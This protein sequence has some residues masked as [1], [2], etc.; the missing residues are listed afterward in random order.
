MQI[1]ACVKHVPDTAANI[2]VTADAA[3]DES[4]KFVVNP[5]D[6]YGV[7]E[8]IQTVNQTGEGEVIIVTVGKAAAENTMRSALAIGAHRGI[9]VKTEAQ[10]LDST[11]TALALKAAIEQ[12]G[13]PDLIFMGKQSVDSEGMQTPYRLARTFGMPVATDVVNF[14]L[15]D[16]GA[17]VEREI[18]D[19]SRE[20][21]RMSLPCVIGAGKGLNEPRYPKLPDILKARKK[22]IVQVSINDLG[23][24][25]PTGKTELLKLNPVPEREP[26]KM[27][28]GTGREMAEQ[29]VQALIEKE[30]VL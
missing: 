7:E 16:G 29:L 20:I 24:D 11:L 19:G 5:Y 22:P 30:Q 17:V 3:F 9:L 18:G 13:M 25:L 27:F 6:E 23:L 14:E 15:Q 26:A 28:T 10:F 2:T 8:A 4:L 21:I 12:D 1:Y